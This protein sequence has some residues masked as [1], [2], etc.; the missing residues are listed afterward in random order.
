[1]EQMR[2]PSFEIFFS[3]RVEVLSRHL[4]NSLFLH[5]H[6]F[7]KRIVVVPN[8][9]VKNWLMLEMAKEMDISAGVEFCTASEMVHVILPFVCSLTSYRIPAHLE[10]ALAIESEIKRTAANLMN[11][12]E[13]GQACWKPMF[14]YLGLSLQEAQAFN[15]KSEKRLV[16]LA[17]QL[18]HLFLL[19]GVHGGKMVEEWECAPACLNWQQQLWL[20]MFKSKNS[21]AADWIAPH[22]LLPLMKFHAQAGAALEVH[23]F[24][25]SYLSKNDFSFLRSIAQ[26]LP[27]KGYLLSPCQI[28]WSDTL[29][30][31]ERTSL[32]KKL[33]KKKV[34]DA[35]EEAL[36]EYLRESNPLLANFGRLGREMAEQ[37]ENSDILAFA[38]YLLPESI[39][40]EEQYSSLFYEEA[41]LEPT[42]NLTLLHAIQS[43]MALM[44]RP[45]PQSKLIFPDYDRSVQVH[46]SSSKLREVE[47]LYETLV[48]LIHQ[49]ARDDVPIYPQD[50]LVMAPDISDYAPFIRTVFDAEESLLDIQMADLITTYQNP[51]VQVFFHLIGLAFGRW[52]VVAVMQLFESPIFLEKHQLSFEDGRMIR[53]WV[54]KAEVRWGFDPE[55]RNELLKRDHCL[56][57]MIENNPSGTW[58]ECFKRLLLGMMMSVDETEPASEELLQLPLD[59]VEISKCGLIGKWI[60]L[61]RSLREDLKKLA[62]GG[63]SS[64]E[65]WIKY[66]LLLAEK[67]VLGQGEK[68]EED[69]LSQR[70]SSLLQ[71]GDKFK[72][73]LFSYI[74]VG[75]HLKAIFNECNINHNET[76]LQAVR[77]C[78]MLPMRAIPSKV[79][80]LI[81]MEEGV[82][83]KADKDHSLNLMKGNPNI[84][85]YPTQTDY[86]RF[87][88]L[89]ILLSARK[90]LI[91]SYRGISETDAKEQPPSLVVSEL[92]SYMDTNYAVGEKKIS[93]LC[94]FKHPF[95]PFDRTY[96][97]FESE[98]KSISTERYRAARA[99]YQPQKHP[100]HQFLPTFTMHP[101]EKS[102]QPERCISL[103]QLNAFARN[104]LKTY[105]NNT[106]G[107]YLHDKEEMDPDEKFVLSHL[108]LYNL[109]KASLKNTPESALS[110]AEKKGGMPFG[111][112]KN[113][114]S[115]T[116]RQ[117]SAQLKQ[118]LEDLGVQAHEIFQIECA[119]Y[120]RHPETTSNR[121]LLPALEF[122]TQDGV[123]IKIS[124]KFPEVS[125]QGLI[126]HLEDSQIDI[127]KVWPQ[128]LVFDALIKKYRLPIENHLLLAKSGKKKVPFYD[129]PLVHLETYLEYYF[130][131]QESVSPLIPEWT[132]QMM[133]S[134]PD[135]L[136][137]DLS[138]TINDSYK[139]MYNE[140]VKWISRG[141]ELPPS[142]KWLDD[143]KKIAEK[144]FGE[145][146]RIWYPSKKTKT[147]KG[148]DE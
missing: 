143:W 123:L 79:I 142:D 34:S 14:Q 144:N 109:K 73:Q 105:F 60:F 128:F 23:F 93:D 59:G 116:V 44:R 124:G 66:L 83:P 33:K 38:L 52:D 115:A 106:L 56:N 64:W 62:E 148:S 146:F 30:D 57:G 87:L 47:N 36:E 12:N 102:V 53:K 101:I 45:D 49:H 67:Y 117:E 28:F 126:A 2:P 118:N 82:F 81:G 75:H 74:T 147:P 122:R 88:F 137:K 127:P 138:Q 111:L 133:K 25:T 39:Q 98:I 6:P 43:D 86:D 11:L 5:A 51:Y 61:M 50:I 119:E 48:S 68:D 65:E 110:L 136:D 130:H 76:H 15:R 54:E 22:H 94:I 21:F 70:L 84:D 131:S 71:K 16:R 121:W 69:L 13:E 140:Y 42:G 1:M 104:P 7:L 46:I 55:H 40:Q 31:K 37:I 120:C 3:N 24:S 125:R 141:S 114:A 129:D 20:K 32:F 8:K 90:Y 100:P 18:A 134:E 17:D 72:D 91:F 135:E 41:L 96:F 132:Y 35:Q 97:S 9:A 19:Y 107:I 10:L 139:K 78:S 145:V 99:F 26:V 29:T 4:Q 27:V 89:E 63:R 80:V 95:S 92:L 58:E 112:F 85:Y 77:F 113:I 103:K 108:D